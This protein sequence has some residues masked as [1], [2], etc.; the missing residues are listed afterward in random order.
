MGYEWGLEW[1]WEW[2]NGESR[3][4]PSFDRNAMAMSRKHPE[5]LAWRRRLVFKASQQLL[6]W[7][8]IR[9]SITTLYLRSEV[10]A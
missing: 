8:P 2:R 5:C 7:R 10:Y 1:K 6:S 4:L 9:K 3:C